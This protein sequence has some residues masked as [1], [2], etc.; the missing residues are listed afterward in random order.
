VR[1][2]IEGKADTCGRRDIGGPHASPQ[3]RQR[4]G[5]RHLHPR[6]RPTWLDYQ[7]EVGLR[8]HRAKSNQADGA[9][10]VVPHRLPL[11]R[12]RPLPFTQAI[13][14]CWRLPT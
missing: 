5:S 4:H 1:V 11:D 14:P 3:A 13:R 9:H 2:P 8:H 7:H 10:G 6:L 12:R